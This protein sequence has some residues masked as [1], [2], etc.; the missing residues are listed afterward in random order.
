MSRDSAKYLWDAEQAAAKVLRFV[1]ARSFDDYLADEMLR[2]AV[3]RQLEIV[4]EAL[5]QLRKIDPDT[6]SR[7][8]DLPQAVALRNVLIHAYATVND[9]LVWGVV[10][11]YL[12]PLHDAL[13]QLMA[14]TDGN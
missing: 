7:I 12:R 11:Q 13:K 8:R 3:E 2:S 9:R 6:A 14:E 5:N 10:E 4:G 1:V